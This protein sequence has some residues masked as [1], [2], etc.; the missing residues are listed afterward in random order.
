MPDERDPLKYQST[1]GNS[2]KQKEKAEALANKTIE[3]VVT[4]EVVQKKKS[5]GQKF[6]G[7]FFGG[8][9]KGAARYI[10]ADVLLP[11]LRNL[12]VDTTSKGIERVVYGESSAQRRRT[13]GYG[14]RIQYNNP[15]ARRDHAYLPNQPAHSTMRQ[16]RRD[17]NEFVLASREEAE[18]VLE[19]L[20]DIVDKYEIAS[21]ADL[22]Q[23]MGL[24]TSA[25]DN[26]WGWISLV[27]AEIRQAR[28][29]YVLDLP[30][31]EEI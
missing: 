10:A 12:L 23:L 21:L 15:I 20:N 29:G 4:G 6:K 7:I 8:E 31:T 27:N 5:V 22:Y 16:V 24:P 1:H 18:L 25:I 13:V 3:K 17:T 28:D 26:K 9:L 2:H 11:A 19:R 14:S 30:P